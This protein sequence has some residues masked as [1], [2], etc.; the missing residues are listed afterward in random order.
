MSVVE[1][2]RDVSIE[3]NHSGK[4]DAVRDEARAQPSP[5]PQPTR[6]PANLKSPLRLGTR[7]RH[8]IRSRSCQ[9]DNRRVT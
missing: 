7:A 5:R 1:D 3:L 2:R 6:L 9:T 8:M 4:T